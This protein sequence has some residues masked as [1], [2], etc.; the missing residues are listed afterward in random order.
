MEIRVELTKTPK[1]KPVPGEKLPF[2][3][4]FSDHMFLMN[5]ETGKGWH[6]P[7]VVPY[8][9]LALSPAAMC[10]HYGQ[11]VFEG[12]KAYYG[13]NGDILLFPG[14]FRPSQR[15]QPAAGDSPHRRG[16]L[17]GRREKAGGGG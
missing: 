14:E 11:T 10:L 5:Y 7:R 12:M 1:A 16:G 15:F 17:S 3:K 9:D 2:G 4:Q 6:D 13:K 8:G